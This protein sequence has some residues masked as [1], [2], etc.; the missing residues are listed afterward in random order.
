VL[1]DA[2]MV[3]HFGFLLFVVFGGFVAWRWPWVI[4]PHLVAAGWGGLI[5]AFGLN[6]PLTRVENDF[7][8]RAG[9]D[10][11]AGG[12]IDTYIEGVLYPERYIG[13]ARALAAV[14]VLVSWAG[15]LRLRQQLRE[16]V[17][18]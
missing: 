11:L 8:T 4:W 3:L 17:P 16:R 10:E 7:R 5:I 9:G 6:C 1:A 2:V 13:L 12:F 14:L 15:F 18:A